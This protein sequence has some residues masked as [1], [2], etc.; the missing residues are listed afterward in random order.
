M[1]TGCPLQVS[2][3]AATHWTGMSKQHVARSAALVIPM[4]VSSIVSVRAVASAETRIFRR[5]S[6]VE[7]RESS[8]RAAAQQRSTHTP[9]S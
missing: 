8:S 1:F 6:S 5:G 3:G 2:Y 4:P 7:S 9:R